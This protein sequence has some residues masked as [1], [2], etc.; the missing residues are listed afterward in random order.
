MNVEWRKID[1]FLGNASRPEL[2]QHRP[3]PIC[4]ATN[5]QAVCELSDFQFYTDAADQPKRTSVRHVRCMRCHAVY[6]NPCYS[7]FGFSV[8]FAEA[9]Q[10]YGATAGRPD[11]Q[12]RWLTARGLLEPGRRLLDVGCYDGRFLARLPSAVHRMGVDIDGPAI[13]RGRRE[14]QAQ[15]IE[16]IHGDFETFGYDRAAP[17]TITMF[18]V[19]EHLP[20][21]VTVLSKLRSISSSTTT[22]VVEVPILQNGQTNDINGFLSVQHMTHFSRGSLQSALQLAGWRVLDRVEMPDYNG[23]RVLAV[24]GDAPLA[25]TWDAADVGLLHDYMASWYRALASVE[26]RLAAFQDDRRFVIWGAG[27]HTEFLYQTTSFFSAHPGRTYA[28]VDSDP[29]KQ[30]R[31][32]RGIGISSPD[33]LKQVDWSAAR[34]VASSYG[35]QESIASAAVRLGVPEDRIV[36]LY[37]R[38]RVY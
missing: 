35:G 11:E 13:E 7:S 23:C 3:C 19:L 27:A 36:R 34:L 26:N 38:V 4:G 16:F 17:D 10:S 6:M 33:L 28:L 9:G 18:H 37:E 32:W 25:P 12:L 5:S 2:S 21:P 8:L 20:R 31:S 24:P 15:N 14:Y 30:G 29:L 22:L 1:S